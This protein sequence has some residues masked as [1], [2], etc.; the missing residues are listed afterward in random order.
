VPF[1]ATLEI[2]GPLTA[3]PEDTSEFTVT[4]LAFNKAGDDTG[5][6]RFKQLTLLTYA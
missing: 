6:F 4:A 3:L 2:S 5:V 1:D